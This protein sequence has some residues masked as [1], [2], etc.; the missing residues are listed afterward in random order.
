M[1]LMWI[2][3]AVRKGRI[4]ILKGSTEDNVADVGTKYIEDAV[5]FKKLLAMC[6]MRF[7]KGLVGAVVLSECVQ[8]CS[9]QFLVRQPS[10][11]YGFEQVLFYEFYV[12][13]MC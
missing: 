2:Q 9:G 8:S 3:H 5:Q 7:L 10:M 11:S 12:A 4:F 1:K 13:I 6:N